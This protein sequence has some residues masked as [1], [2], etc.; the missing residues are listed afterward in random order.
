VKV[1]CQERPMVDGRKT[2]M[3]KE[4]KGQA[5]TSHVVTLQGCI[6]ERLLKGRGL[7][8]ISH[9]TRKGSTPWIRI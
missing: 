1:C 4:V 3:G 9:G 8:H 5:D 7:S 6:P 2:L